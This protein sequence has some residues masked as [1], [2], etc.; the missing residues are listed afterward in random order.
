MTRLG[1]TPHALNASLQEAKEAVADA[2]VNMT[3]ARC[4]GFGDFG[5]VVY[6]RSPERAFVSGFLLPRFADIG[7]VDETSDIHIAVIGLDFQVT[8]TATG[9]AIVRPSFSAYVRVLPQWAELIE[10]RLGIH[11]TFDLIPAVRKEIVQKIRDATKALCVEEGLV[12]RDD[13]KTVSRDVRRQRQLRRT[14]LKEEA[15]KRVYKEYGIESA[16]LPENEDSI[17]ENEGTTVPEVPIDTPPPERNA[18]FKFIWGDH[19]VPRI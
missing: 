8:K 3:V 17:D 2:L 4:S 14:A 12:G 5:R 19:H 15:T 7:D 18:T 10:G 9:A 6:G 11:P 13:P 1:V 16:S